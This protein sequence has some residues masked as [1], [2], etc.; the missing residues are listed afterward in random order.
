MTQVSRRLFSA[1]GS[2]FGIIIL[3]FFSASSAV[4][5]NAFEQEG[6]VP[7]YGRSGQEL[8]APAGPAEIQE[9]YLTVGEAVDLALE[10][11]LSLRSA[12]LRQR[13][14]EIETRRTFNDFLPGLSGSAS[15]TYQDTSASVAGST[16]PLTAGFGFQAR[17]DLSGELFASIRQT[18]HAFETG[19]LSIAEA[20]EM[21]RRDVQK[22][23]YGLILTERRIV[24]SERK[25]E[26]AR[27]R[28]VLAEQDWEMGLVSEYQVLSARVSYENLKP[29]LRRLRREY[30][31]RIEE[32]KLMLGIDKA[33]TL[34]IE[35]EIGISEVVLD[36][37]ALIRRHLEGR[38]DLMR[39]RSEIEGHRLLQ[40]SRRAGMAP[41]LSLSF[42]L[43]GSVNGPFSNPW[44]GSSG[45][46]SSSYPRLSL[47]LS[48]PIDPLLPGSRLREEMAKTDVE[49]EAA[50]LELLELRK[51]AELTI[52][53][54][55]ENLEERMEYISVLRLNVE[56][57]GK[58][59]SIAEE[60]YELGRADLQ[61]VEE[62]A[63]ELEQAEAALLEE[64]YNFV[65][66][67]LDLEYA[68]NTDL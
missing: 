7:R 36:A 57:A 52:E 48:L 53:S 58:A 63:L 1:A 33:E 4:A 14:L 43:G 27:K 17:L 66:A 12:E 62:A 49:I 11:N 3:V 39:K 5:Q 21:M 42:S 26:A 8:R 24:L 47:S 50:E 60:D 30:E 25:L 64:E 9:R 46:W 54:L 56:L 61:T 51:S 40:G 41:D 59:A 34:D 37:E 13:K 68:L 20:R 10:N 22:L 15:L 2:L 38:F 55:V 44:F 16:S 19:K 18:R 6:A 31:T 28:Y 65:I 23:F 32:F 29:E 45:V 35:G 67:L